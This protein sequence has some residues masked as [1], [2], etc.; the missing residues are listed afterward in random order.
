[1]KIKWPRNPEIS[2]LII[3]P[4]ELKSVSQRG[5]WT[6]VDYSTI[7]NSQHGRKG[8][9]NAHQGFEWVMKGSVFVH[10][11]ERRSVLRQ[12]NLPSEITWMN[13]KDIGLSE[14]AQTLE[15]KYSMVSII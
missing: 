8:N 12:E 15:D 7:R 11:V 4:K 6:L 5:T 2:H 1:M 14:I 9:L 10:T 13:L 3:Y